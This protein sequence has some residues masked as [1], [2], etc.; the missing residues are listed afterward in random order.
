M[1]MFRGIGHTRA[2]HNGIEHHLN[3]KVR[4][5][6]TW[7]PSNSFELVL[8]NRDMRPLW[9]Y[10]A[11]RFNNKRPE[12][13]S[14]TQCEG[15]WCVQFLLSVDRKFLY[16][17]GRPLQI[18]ARTAREG[19]RIERHVATHLLGVHCIIDTTWIMDK[20]DRC[21]YCC[22]EE[23]FLRHLKITHLAVVFL[24]VASKTLHDAK[25]QSLHRR[26]QEWV[27]RGHV[28][29]DLNRRILHWI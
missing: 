19:E 9:R 22:F 21:S 3:A 15:P 23:A 28:N 11:V 29:N 8:A 24:M 13:V 17:H 1:T 5:L 26:C 7:W 14:C 18:G 4:I 20:I 25:S 6:A 12:F 16:F 27:L 2:V 10:D